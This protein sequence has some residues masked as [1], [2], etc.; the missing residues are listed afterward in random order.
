MSKKAI[1]GKNN[2]NFR[3]GMRHT[4]Q[5]ACWHNMKNRCS[6]KNN[7][8]YKDYG[9]RGISYHKDFK[10]FSKWW[11]YVK[12]MWDRFEK[13][14]PGVTPTID[15]IDN[16]GDYTYKNI[17]IL[18]LSGNIKRRNA[19]HGNPAKH[20]RKSV[21]AICKETN[22]KFYFQSTREAERKG[23]AKCQNIS[24]CCNGKK[25]SAGGYYW[26]FTSRY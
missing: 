23:F 3:H 16:D 5:Y 24:L 17:Q 13:E 4:V 10:V 15:R 22:K 26:E 19:E 9:G 20:Q 18:S 25:K 8:S 14:N 2:P 21:T 1:T 11:R 6:N 7:N 12:P